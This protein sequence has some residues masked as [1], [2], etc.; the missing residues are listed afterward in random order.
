[1]LVIHTGSRHLGLEVAKYYQELAYK[2][3]KDLDV[4]DKIK[5]V[6]ADLKQKEGKRN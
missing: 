3:L 2:Q 5:A 4:G 1:M 6:I